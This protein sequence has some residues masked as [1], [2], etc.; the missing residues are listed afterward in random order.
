MVSGLIPSLGLTATVVSLKQ[1][2]L[3]PFSP[4]T[5]DMAEE[6][7]TWLMPSSLWKNTMLHAALTNNTFY[8]R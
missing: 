5:Q 2:I 6:Q 7:L 1:E 4:A 3:P 8:G